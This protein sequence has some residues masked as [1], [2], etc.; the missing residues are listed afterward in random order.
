MG[1]ANFTEA[2][3]RDAVR[4]ITERGYSAVQNS[5]G[6]NR[7]RIKLQWQVTI[8]TIGSTVRFKKGCAKCLFGVLYVIRN[9]ID[10]PN[11]KK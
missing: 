1:K 10:E 4:Q 6:S 9:E 11:S 3:K 8:R 7:S 2:F 5:R